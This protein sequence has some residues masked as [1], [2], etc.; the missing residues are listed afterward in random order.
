MF[1][2][3]RFQVKFLKRPKVFSKFL[4]SATA[5]G[6]ISVMVLMPGASVQLWFNLSKRFLKIEF[7][8]LPEADFRYSLV[9][10]RKDFEKFRPLPR[11]DLCALRIDFVFPERKY[12]LVRAEIRLIFVQM[13]SQILLKLTVSVFEKTNSHREKRGKS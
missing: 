12:S 7:Q 8:L 10:L 4:I 9:S 6:E 2:M 1:A 5:R 3:G 13:C 11:A